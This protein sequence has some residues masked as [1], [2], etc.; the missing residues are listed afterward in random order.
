MQLS[1]NYTWLL[2]DVLGRGS[3]G[4]VYHGRH[5]TTGAP[6]A[7]KVLSVDGMRRPPELQERESR[8]LAELDH[9]NIVRLL[10]VEEESV[11]RHRVVVMEV[12]SGGSLHSILNEPE[13]AYGLSEDDFLQ[14]LSD[15]V[16]G[17]NH[18]REKG[19]VH[20]DLK[21]GNIMRAFRADG[22]ATY[23]LTDFDTARWLEDGEQF[24]SLCGTEEYLHPD[25]YARAVLRT[26]QPRAYHAT[27]DLWSIGVTIYHVATGCLPFRPHAG[28]R[29]DQKL[30]HQITTRKP[31]GAISG[32]QE[33]ANEKITWSDTLPSSC[34][35]SECLKSLLVPILASVLEADPGQCWS[36][37]QFFA[38]TKDLLQR[39]LLH[40]YSL[41]QHTLHRVYYHAHDTWA[42]LQELLSGL[43]GVTPDLQL[44]F[45]EGRPL[46]ATA[47]GAAA[48]AGGHLPATT[49]HDPVVLASA[50]TGQAQA[51][52]P[53][54][55]E[56]HIPTFSRNTDMLQD[57]HTAQDAASAAIQIHRLSDRVAEEQVVARRA[58]SW[59]RSKFEDETRT[60]L[61][62]LAEVKVRRDA[63]GDLLH[64]T[65]RLCTLAT[66]QEQ[67]ASAPC[68]VTEVEAAVR[69]ACGRLEE[70]EG[71]LME[72][73]ASCAPGGDLSASWCQSVGFQPS[74]CSVERLA[75]LAKLS[76]DT[77]VQFD[78]DLQQRKMSAMDVH[79]HNL[80]K[81]KLEA[82]LQ[83][84]LALFHDKVNSQHSAF[85]QKSLAWQRELMERKAEVR[86]I[87]ADMDQLGSQLKSVQ[88]Q[89]SALQD[90]C[91]ESLEKMATMAPPSKHLAAYKDVSREIKMH[92]QK[93]GLKESCEDMLGEQVDLL[94]RFS[95]I[96]NLTLDSEVPATA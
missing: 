81:Q 34:L 5:R 80:E 84:A 85:E 86:V 77:L 44:F 68:G 18:L 88:E 82:N 74:D 62:R 52:A 63:A 73:D 4:C 21:P 35:L 76:L 10:A 49:P 33:Q 70:L 8:V 39:E 29:R 89:L 45:N 96:T 30:M 47:V 9:P 69:S 38:A 56:L 92:K 83:E 90:Q 37:D 46:A 61:Q 67:L 17:M 64:K 65:R 51:A 27:V 3:T 50:G 57:V 16:A 11:T 95:N 54:Q 6:S 48:A 36:F 7:I 23:K 93:E 1:Q 42:Q 87:G 40:V 91:F 31:K 59:I 66:R 94:K 53:R 14:V 43:T 15:V 55:I 58:A 72:V 25:M 20:R 75:V 71:R 13:N 60:A 32:V 41:P 24:V 19:I 28:P 2:T 79:M 78:R 26:S 22:K 12:C